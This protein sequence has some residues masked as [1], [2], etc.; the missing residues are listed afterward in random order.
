MTIQ[1]MDHVGIVVENLKAAIDLMARALGETKA[2]TLLER[3]SRRGEGAR[4]SH[5]DRR[6]PRSKVL[7]I[8][9]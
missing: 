5:H 8:K 2:V 4:R 1:R 6:A 7:A 9:V 3:T